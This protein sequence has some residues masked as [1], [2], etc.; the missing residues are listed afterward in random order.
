M[1]PEVKDLFNPL[2]ALR[3]LVEKPHTVRLPF[4]KKEA[5]D[6]E[7]GL[8]ANDLDLCIGCGNCAKICNCEAIEMVEVEGVPDGPGR[9]TLRPRV[10]YGRCSFCGQCVDVCPTGSLK[11]S[12]DYLLV[13]EDRNDFVFVPDNRRDDGRGW[14]S[15]PQASLLVYERIEMPERDPNERKHDFDWVLLGFTEEQAVLEAQRC[16]GCGLCIQSC[17]TQ[18]DIPEYIA[19]IARRDYEEALRI[20]F[21]TNPFSEVCGIVCTH[22]CETACVYEHR[23]DPI[24]IRF[25][26][27]FATSQIDDYRRVLQP[28]I[29]PSTGKRVAIIGAGPAGLTAAY[30]LRLKGHEVTIFEALPVPGGMM[31][32]G[33][34]RY[35]LPQKTLDKEIGYILSLGVDLRLNTRVGTD[36]P[37]Q[38]LVEEFDA[39]FISVGHHKPWTL[40]IPGEDARGVWQAIEFLKRVNLGEPVEVGKRVVVVGGGDVA[41]DACRTPLRLGA[42]ESYVMYRRRVED[43]PASDEE[44]REALDEGVVF[45]PQTLPVEI[46]KDSDGRMVAVKYVKTRMV[47]QGPGKRPRPVPIEDQVYTLE[48]DMLIAAIGQTV[49]LSFVPE[50]LR[51]AITDERGKIVA[52]A[53]RQTPVPKIFAGG[54]IFNPRADI[55]SA[56]A[57]GRHAATGIDLFLRGEL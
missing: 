43:M 31:R 28:Q 14:R 44:K 52:N 33:I 35:R 48:A 5:A 37:F 20:M 29:P 17:P 39:V 49:D 30:Y 47:D 8:H 7:R 13:S 27:G 10:D 6:R 26:K 9:T 55:I 54:D 57:D 23:G 21:R 15:E 56:V 42:E 16:L 34:P 1:A 19:A 32:V 12:R 25:L 50:D 24:Q 18:M 36:V 41:M 2:T 38:Q 4:E 22:R 51:R 11:L 3:F 53:H 46:V 45:L 40:G